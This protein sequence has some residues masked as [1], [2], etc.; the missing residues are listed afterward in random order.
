MLSLAAYPGT[1]AGRDR[2]VLDH[3]PRLSRPA[4]VWRPQD[5]LVEDEVTA[6]GTIAP[7]AAVF[8]TT[9]ECPWRCAMCD[10]W[11]H[12]TTAPTPVGA[13]PAQ[14]AA[15]RE[16]LRQLPRPVSRLK[17]Y[18]AGSFFD[19]GAVPES[20]YQD[21]AHQL[22]GLQ[23]V[24]VEAHPALVGHRVDRFLDALRRALPEQAAP[25]LE[26]AMGLETVHPTAL[27]NLNKRMTVETFAEAA[28]ALRA[29]QIDVRA[30]VLVGTPFIAPDEQDAWLLRSV[31]AAFAAG[32][33]VVSLVPMRGGNGTLEAL[34]PS[35]TFAEPRLAD[36][37][38]SAAL[39][40]GLFAPRG[41]VLVDIWDVPRFAHCA[42]CLDA[43]RA[44]L[45]AMNL[46]QTVRPRLSCPACRA[47]R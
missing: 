23:H 28:A 24:V 32:A 34:S 27:A 42:V 46:S 5:V 39:A 2:F 19:A 41:R 25:T 14:L 47:R 22:H 8:L 35:G 9:R 1:A 29:R 40:L 12:A 45:Q 3:R 36:I 20:D 7:T 6:A 10:L 17:L 38:R 13:V 37:E 30:F 11:Q 43:R 31:D 18:N 33:S 26:V 16:R 21:I 4:D 15:A 44:R